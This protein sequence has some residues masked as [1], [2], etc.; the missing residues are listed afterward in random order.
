[1]IVANGRR[2]YFHHT[3]P[4]M[5]KKGTQFGWANSRPQASNWW[6]AIQMWPTITSFYVAREAQMLSLS[7]V[8]FLEL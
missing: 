1:M 5:T 3:L 6:P 8:I 4:F 2:V 7:L